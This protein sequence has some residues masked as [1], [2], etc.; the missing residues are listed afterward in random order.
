MRFI[1]ICLDSQ[2]ISIPGEENAT[3]PGRC[4]S[5]EDWAKIESTE[6]TLVCPR[7]VSVAGINCQLE[8]C[9]PSL[10]RSICRV[11]VRARH[12]LGWQSTATATR[13]CFINRTRSEILT[14]RVSGA[15]MVT[16][17]AVCGNTVSRLRRTALRCRHEGPLSIVRQ[18]KFGR[19][20][21]DSYRRYLNDQNRNRVAAPVA[22]SS[23]RFAIALQTRSI[24]R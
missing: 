12:H 9:W 18:R 21:V 6:E 5:Q 20:C 17:A 2:L 11:T 1:E 7:R 13:P 16:A 23:A 10:L 8:R 4:P 3:V 19:V 15:G 22:K 24:D 14:E